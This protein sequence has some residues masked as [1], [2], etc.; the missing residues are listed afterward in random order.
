[1]LV[2]LFSSWLA[3]DYL[4][5]GP[6]MAFPLHEQRE[7]EISGF[8]SS[9]Y[10]DTCPIR[11]GLHLMTSFN[12]NYLP[13]S[14]YIVTLEV[15][16]SMYEFGRGDVIQFLKGSQHRLKMKSKTIHTVRVSVILGSFSSYPLVDM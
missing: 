13:I 16:A 5:A 1:M 3:N 9:N 15:R 4:L 12:R 10:K 11:L 2:G 7:N 8:S 6:H 14:K